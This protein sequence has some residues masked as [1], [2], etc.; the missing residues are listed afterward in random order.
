[1]NAIGA[2]LEPGN[3]LEKYQQQEI[4]L[5]K[6]KIESNEEIIAKTIHHIQKD[7]TKYNQLHVLKDKADEDHYKSFIL[8]KRMSIINKQENILHIAPDG[9]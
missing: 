3:I 4:D 9:S 6:H 1:M 5:L 8:S 7:Q 2:E